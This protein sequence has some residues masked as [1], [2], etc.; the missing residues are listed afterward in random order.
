MRQMNAWRRAIAF[1]LCIAGS[2]FLSAC[3]GYQ[4]T[5]NETVVR[6]PAPLY[7]NFQVADRNLQVCLD[8]AIKDAEATAPD[9]LIQLNCSHAGI[10]TLEG[11]Q[12][13]HN[14]QQINLS[15][16]Q[17]SDLKPLG[18]MGRVQLLLLSNNNLKSIPEILTLPRLERLEL[19]NNSEL[20]CDDVHQLQQNYKGELA[21][22]AH[23]R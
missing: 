11:L 7:T 13:F 12:A 6:S 3:K 18:Q 22:P 21:M 16:N 15:H 4:L 14:L 9:Q 5:F 23:C 17:L 1:G 2:I 10:E 20:Y 19:D 8:Q